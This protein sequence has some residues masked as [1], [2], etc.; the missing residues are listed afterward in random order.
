MQW[1]V[2]Q[3]RTMPGKVQSYFNIL[4]HSLRASLVLFEPFSKILRQ[5]QCGSQ[6][7]CH[8]VPAFSLSLFFC[9]KCNGPN[10]WLHIRIT[11]A[12][13]KTIVMPQLRGSISEFIFSKTQ[14]PK[15]GILLKY[16]PPNTDLRINLLLYHLLLH[17]VLKILN[18]FKKYSAYNHIK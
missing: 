7:L 15:T 9:I 13:L 17:F 2:P 6:A 18:S 8:P 16:H 12:T 5:L 10:I 3:D 1:L 4:V 11:W 14:S